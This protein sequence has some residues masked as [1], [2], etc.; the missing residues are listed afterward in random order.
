MLKHFKALTHRNPREFASRQLIG[1]NQ[2]TCS[3]YRRSQTTG[4]S[5][6]PQGQDLGRNAN[7][8]GVLVGPDPSVG[9]G[10]RIWG[11]SLI[12]AQYCCGFRRPD[13]CPIPTLRSRS[14]RF[15]PGRI[16]HP[17]QGPPPSENLPGC[18]WLGEASRERRND[19]IARKFK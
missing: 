3:V 10:G 19:R 1:S 16:Q 14:L 5:I 7:A 2:A 11:H 15:A 9:T 13:V 8:A 4:R 17:V 12:G 6:E 18:S